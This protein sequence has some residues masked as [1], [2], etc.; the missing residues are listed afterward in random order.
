MTTSHTPLMAQYHQIKAQYVDTLLFFQVG[1]FYELF[2]DDAVVASRFLAITLTKRGKTNGMDIP[3]CGVPV[4]ALSFYLAKLVRG[5]FSVALCDQVSKPEAGTVVQRAV[6]KVYT[7]GT[8]TDEHMLNEKRPSYLVALLRGALHYELLIL[9]TLT[10]QQMST[11]IPLDDMR[12]LEAELARC[13]PDEVLIAAR[14]TAL[15]AQIKRWGYVVSMVHDTYDSASAMLHAYLTRVQPALV[16]QLG[17]PAWYAQTAYVVLDAATQ[18]NLALLP[19][20]SDVE[21]GHADLCSA[22]DR[23]TTAMGARL[24]K[25][26]L[27]RPLRDARALEERFDTIDFLLHDAMRAQQI[28]EFLSALADIERIVGRMV[29]LRATLSDYR[30]LRDSLAV[31]AQLSAVLLQASERSVLLDAVV[32]SSDGYESL[33]DL[34]QRAVYDGAEEQRIKEGYDATLDRLRVL[35]RDGH[36]QVQQYATAQ[37]AAHDIAS[38]KILYTSVAGYFIEVTKTHTHKVPPFYKHVQTLAGRDRFVTAELSALERALQSAS[39]DAQERE[40]EVY[41][42]FEATVCTYAGSLR[43]TAAALAT[44]DVLAGFAQVARQ[45]RYVRPTFTHEQRIAITGGRHPV[46]EQMLGGN[47]F[48]AND[49]VLDEAQ[50]LLIITGPNMGGKSTY[51][52]QG[53]LISLLAQC[54]SFVPARSAQLMLVDRIFTRI[55]AGD[56]V[57][58][59]KST[60]LVE[61]EEAATICSQATPQSLVILDE[62]GRGTSTDDGRVLAQAIIEYVL[63]QVRCLTLFATHYHELTELAQTQ[64]AIK[65]YRM[66]CHKKGTELFFLHRVEPGVAPASFGIEVARLAQLPP[67]VIARARELLAQTAEY[68]VRPATRVEHIEEVQCPLALQEVQRMLTELALDDITPRRALDVLAQLKDLLQ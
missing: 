48:S 29:V 33:Y 34:L 10:A 47:H 61:M 1:D 28:Q 35:A 16:P 45:W 13:A 40:K 27:V 8:L 43:R 3:L 19:H 24:L 54:G 68:S 17:E 67:R 5:G 65:N 55:G 6:T 22:V 58:Q 11:T 9:E 46:V 56:N 38:L 18:R 62:V 32:R 51:L 53:A 25:K 4:H 44:L 36:A 20:S 23:T 37:A 59:G 26:W 63:D 2:F 57:A 60:F 21:L 41:A 39:T 64:S 49:M 42:A 12:T 50:R 7:P 30:V 66:A 15:Q 31:I 14:D 52:R